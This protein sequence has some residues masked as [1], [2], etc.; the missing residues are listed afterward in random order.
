MCLV[1]KIS[2]IKSMPI[3]GRRNNQSSFSL[4]GGIL[5]I[6]VLLLTFL[7][8]T[9]PFI[10]ILTDLNL[11]PLKQIYDIDIPLL[12][13]WI[14][15]NKYF[16]PILFLGPFVLQGIAVLTGARITAFIMV[17]MVVGERFLS[18]FLDSIRI[19][20]KML[21]Y[22]D[23]KQFLS[24]YLL[25]CRLALIV[26]KGQ[27]LV[28]SIAMGLMTVSFAITVGCTFV[29]VRLYSVLPVSLHWLFAAVSS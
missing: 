10:I 27:N 17:L 19:R 18:E 1:H 4:L 2:K 23:R 8:Y 15:R 7:G 9:I 5:Y 12:Q 21:V 14:F 25:Y 28:A 16:T 22:A 11:D 29:T 13:E 6:Y 26:R 3:A 20:T 24:L